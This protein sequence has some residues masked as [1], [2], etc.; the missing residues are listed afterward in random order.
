MGDI[1][2]VHSLVHFFTFLMVLIPITIIIS[3]LTKERGE[4]TISLLWFVVGLSPLAIY[5]LF[6]FLNL[7][8]IVLLPAEETLMHSVISHTAVIIAFLSVGWFV[9][10]FKKRYITLF[11]SKQS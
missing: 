10:L 2:L 5:H 9:Y 1:L 8:N 6:E 4:L 11:F 7:F 3:I